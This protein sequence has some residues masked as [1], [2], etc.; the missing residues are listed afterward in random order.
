MNS[1][2][3]QSKLPD[4][5]WAS[6]FQHYSQ[7]PNTTFHPDQIEKR[8]G[9]KMLNCTDK[10]IEELC[11]PDQIDREQIIE[12]VRQLQKQE[13]KYL[14]GVNRQRWRMMKQT[15]PERDPDVE[16]WPDLVLSD[17][18]IIGLEKVKAEIEQ[19]R[20]SREEFVQAG[21]PILID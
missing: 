19:E 12:N 6:L 3:T 9:L 13:L 16:E 4:S 17:Q 1:F 10:E 18:D 5:V 14:A 11:K 8:M 21:K 7:I 15:E 20:L 2:T